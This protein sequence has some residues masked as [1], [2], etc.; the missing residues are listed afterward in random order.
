MSFFIR[1]TL[2][3]SLYLNL[4]SPII[5]RMVAMDSPVLLSSMTHVLYV[6]ALLAGGHPLRG[7]ELKT[8]NRALLELLEH[9]VGP[10]NL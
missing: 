4:N 7:G 5:Q 2:L 1:Y 9:T 3:A 8:M 10:E 6:Q